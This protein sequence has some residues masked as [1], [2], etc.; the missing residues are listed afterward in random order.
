MKKTLV[1]LA[2]IF[3]LGV[4]IAYAQH[5]GVMGGQGGWYCPYS[6]QWMGPGMMGKGMMGSVHGRTR[7]DG[8][9]A[10]NDGRTG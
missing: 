5:P 9:R 6:G 10:G 3:I 8:V 2:V 4:A 7:H 1:A